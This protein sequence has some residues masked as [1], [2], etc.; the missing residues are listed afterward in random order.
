MMAVGYT[1]ARSP[2]VERTPFHIG[3]RV[4]ILLSNALHGILAWVRRASTLGAGKPHIVDYPP[5]SSELVFDNGSIQETG[6][7]L[8]RQEQ[9]W[10][11]HIDI[12]SWELRCSGNSSICIVC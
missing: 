4:A 8:I 2:V 7:L 5:L 10:I 11:E 1:M 6:D 3:E 9:V 12:T